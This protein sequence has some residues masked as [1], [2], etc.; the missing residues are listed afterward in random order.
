[1]G[2]GV[3]GAR[4]AVRGAPQTVAM[5]A[6][7]F[8]HPTNSTQK[9]RGDLDRGLGVVV[10]SEGAASRIAALAEICNDAVDWSTD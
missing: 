2:L 4:E 9:F 5:D 8:T 6:V 1:M 3:K 7:L 10:V